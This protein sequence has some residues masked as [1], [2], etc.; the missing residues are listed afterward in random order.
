MS[1]APSYRETQ[2]YTT[3]WII[4]CLTALVLLPFVLPDH[5]SSGLSVGL[6]LGL[7]TGFGLLLLGRLTVSVDEQA[8]RWHFGYVG[9]P[10]WEQPLAE[11]SHTDLARGTRF[12]SG[13]KGSAKHREYHVQM[14]S[15]GVRLY[16]HDGRSVLLGSA[17]A[18]RLKA[19]I[20]ARLDASIR[21]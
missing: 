4:L 19:F 3:L 5:Q 8:V 16:R 6:L 7:S 18:E 15:P 1:P 17:Q 2:T 10:S 9:W 20:D 13:I 11:L 14:H 12:G 21:R